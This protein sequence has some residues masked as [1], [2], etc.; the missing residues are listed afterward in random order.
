[1]GPDAP[2]HVESCFPLAWD[3]LESADKVKLLDTNP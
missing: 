1:M 2:A 3:S